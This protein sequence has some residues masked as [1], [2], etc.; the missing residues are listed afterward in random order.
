MSLKEVRQITKT[1]V[2]VD[3][4]PLIDH[5]DLLS[6]DRGAV[7]H[8]PE[9]ELT[10]AEFVLRQFVASGALPWL[11]EYEIKP[12]GD[13]AGKE[14]F[15]DPIDSVLAALLIQKWPIVQ[16]DK[17]SPTALVIEAS[18]GRPR[19]RF[20]APQ[21]SF[22]FLDMDG[23]P[24]EENLEW[25]EANLSA[26]G[27]SGAIAFTG[28]SFHYI[29]DFRIPLLKLPVFCSRLIKTLTPIDA[30]TAPRLVE[31]CEG[32][33]VA[34]S[35]EEVRRVAKAILDENS[36]IHIPSD[37]KGSW[38][39]SFADVRYIAHHLLDQRLTGTF[40]LAIRITSKPGRPTPSLI[41]LIR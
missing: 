15:I 23:I 10:S 9:G 4:P 14:D 35:L 33:E 31:I 19:E 29:S 32:L 3:L 17:S 22:I 34:D 36:K 11:R 40:G 16:K 27:F 24:T 28:A 7:F 30:W 41:S 6:R 12:H 26:S 21:E 13:E 5:P 39:G 18:L 37:S 25:I 8:L 20:T 1:E 38:S 2:V